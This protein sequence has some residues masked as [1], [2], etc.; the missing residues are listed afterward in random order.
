M[1]S[2]KTDCR[3]F[4]S[5]RPC[6]PHK[7]HGVVC[8]TCT[9]FYD[10]VRTRIL[11]VKLAADGDVLRTTSLL[12]A[13]HRR[14]PGAH[15]TWVTAPSAV[16]LF[17]GNPLVDRVI[18]FNGSMPLPISAEA[19]D[20]VLC[21]DAAAD[22]CSLAHAAHGGPNGIE[23][24][25]FDLDERG[26]ARPLGP[27]AEH[28][29]N[30]GL[31]DDL[32]R[33]NA[34]TYQSIMADVLGVPYERERPMLALNAELSARSAELRA[35]HAPPAGKSVIGLNTGAGRRWRFKRWTDDGMTELCRR[36]TAAGHTVLLLGG[37]DEVERMAR[38]QHATN[39]GAINTGGHNSLPEFASIVDACDIV[40]TG[41]TLA[42]HIAVA[43]D[44]PV[45]ALFGPT[46][47]AEIELFDTGDHVVPELDCLVCYKQDCDFQPNC[48]ESISCDTVA[49]AIEHWTEA[50]AR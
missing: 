25:G 5:D 27:A 48:M 4:H 36:L 34:R 16:P 15:V 49:G 12:P 7:Q 18:A 6:A 17:D 9:E 29:F 11:L 8:G 22:A 20:V 24:V 37:P 45:V 1:D 30:M 3:H 33:A 41:D 31:R 26:T 35:A 2:L 47:A 40:V 10:P 50:A 19:F 46:S 42:L 21:P 23:R 13:I 43:R 32:K 44:K 28:W 14:W 38:L 39:D